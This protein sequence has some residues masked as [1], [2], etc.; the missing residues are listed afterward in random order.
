MNKI[1]TPKNCL[2]ENNIAHVPR[3]KNE[4][5]IVHFNHFLRQIIKVYRE[6]MFKNIF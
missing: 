2:E 3:A 5:K 6:K 1:F 4:K